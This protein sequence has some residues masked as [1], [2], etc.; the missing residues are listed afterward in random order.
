[1]FSVVLKSV[2][3]NHPFKEFLLEVGSTP[4]V[5]V[6]SRK[7]GRKMKKT[8]PRPPTAGID[9]KNILLYRNL[10]KKLSFE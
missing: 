4:H 2:D 3:F 1:M 8:I 9:V 5:V 6:K 10:F 7:G